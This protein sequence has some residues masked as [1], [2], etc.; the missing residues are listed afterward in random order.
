MI[1]I[2]E[3]IIFS[4]QKAGG[5]SIY[6]SELIARISKKKNIIFYEKDNQNIFRNKL[7]IR[8]QK[9]SYLY[10]KFLRY[11]PFLKSLPTKSVFHSSYYRVSLQ[12]DI[13]NITTVHD[14]TYEYFRSGIEMFV[15]SWQ[16]GFAI[17]K[18][19]GIICI[20]ENT[21]HDLLK[22]YTG[23]DESKIKVIYNGVSNDFEKLENA[24]EFL[25]SGFE[26]LKN[27]KY[28]LYI[29]DRSNYKNFNV[30][31]NVL[32]KLDE[33]NFIVVGG[34]EFN[35]TEKEN[36]EDIKH[37]VYHFRGIDGYNLNILYNNA[38]CLIYPSSYEG[39]GIPVVEAM[40]A[41]C[42][43]VS[44]NVSSIP[45]VAGDAGL[46][47]NDINIDQFVHEIQKL[48]NYEFRDETINKGLIQARQFSWDKCFN[49]TYAF[50]E[51][52]WNNKFGE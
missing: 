45:E 32:K 11:I 35:K 42:P 33:Y 10:L 8:V 51:E 15:H 3:N 22:F 44:T 28:I 31:I 19:D 27:K 16:K 41:G 21:K 17:R 48:E 18:S 9:E 34:K 49:E 39:F 13:V 20:S 37:R 25:T 5:I 12:K 43:V 6:W 30:A 1:V 40:K 47:V 26:I 46:L 2:Y 24:Q 14:F 38:F 52:V 7:N 23:I 29:G 36:M 50:Y 4:L